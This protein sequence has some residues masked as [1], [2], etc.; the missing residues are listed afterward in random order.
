MKQQKIEIELTNLL[1]DLI[2][3]YLKKN[4]KRIDGS[5]MEIFCAVLNTLTVLASNSEYEPELLVQFI[6]KKFSAAVKENRKLNK[7]INAR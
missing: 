6:Q 2:K 5:G 4:D 1:L 7:K 3:D